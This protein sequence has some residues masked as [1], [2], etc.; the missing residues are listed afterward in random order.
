MQV[1]AA[2]NLTDSRDAVASRPDLKKCPK[3]DHFDLA[4]Q[5]TSVAIPANLKFVGQA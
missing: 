3:S 2:T 5:E 4:L 1:V